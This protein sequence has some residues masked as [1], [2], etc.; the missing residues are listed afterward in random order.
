[1][2]ASVATPTL[3][4]QRLADPHATAR[5]VE[6]QLSVQPDSRDLRIAGAL[7]Y[8]Q[9]GIGSRAMTLMNHAC[10]DDATRTVIIAQIPRGERRIPW[11]GL[12]ERYQRNLAAFEARTG[13]A[14][15][16]D[17]AWKAG[18]SRLQLIETFDGELH[19]FD[20]G[21]A[22]SDWLPGFVPRASALSN[23]VL[24]QRWEGHIVR[25]I[26]VCGL[27]LGYAATAV[28][29]ASRETF[30][31]F[32]APVFIVESASLAWAVIFHLHDWVSYL[33]EPRVICV[34]GEAPLR[35]LSRELES[36]DRESAIVFDGGPAWPGTPSVE[37][38]QEVV[39]V[40]AARR[41]TQRRVAFERVDAAARTSLARRAERLIAARDKQS[42]VRIL[43]VTSRFT[44]VLQYTLRD[45]L[46][47]FEAAGHSTRLVLEADDSSYF[48][49][50]ALTAEIEQFDPDL[51]ITVDHL[52]REYARIIPPTLPMAAWIQDA[53][54]N[55]NCAEAGRS[56][57]PLQ[58]VFGVG[59]SPLTRQFGYP[60]DQFL[61]C[62]TPARPP[63]S[64]AAPQDKF[65]CDVMYMSNV[66]ETP[67][68]VHESFRK[69]LAAPAVPLA[70]AL[71]A[72]VA[73]LVEEGVIGG[74]FQCGELVHTLFP[75]LCESPSN[76]ELIQAYSDHAR[77]L[78]DRFMRQRV[79]EDIAAWAD[80]R[81]RRL[82]LYGRG[83]ESD[84]RWRRFARGPVAPGVEMS[85]AW[86]SAT[87][88]IH[89][90]LN[91]GLHQRVL[92]GLAAGAFLLIQDSVWES[93]SGISTKLLRIAE[94]RQDK[95]PVRVA[96]GDF[97][98]AMQS[99]AREFLGRICS[100][101]NNGFLMT[102]ELYDTL[103]LAIDDQRPPLPALLWS[104]Y[105]NVV[106]HGRARLWERLD[107]AVAH[108]DERA[109]ISERMRS[110]LSERLTY[111]AFVEDLIRFVADGVERA[112]S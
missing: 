35:E 7:A 78:L 74:G 5:E 75:A 17:S 44:T 76:N 85:S 100:D 77:T 15:R 20:R 31:T 19:I 54:P 71:F 9:L 41:E 38:I 101:V 30:L 29:Q 63:V 34:A 96:M 49:P 28:L 39:D 24:R 53:L 59:Y 81:G 97:P 56:V 13:L 68:Q 6:A 3:N 93:R 26:I 90:G 57:D 84:P 108:P 43:G 32:S 83:W 18:V 64:G 23:E 60:C 37:A 33:N 88:C 8:A 11:S 66:A 45:L 102:Q 105:P 107:W 36:H 42:P 103:R 112:R 2:A 109:E 4:I 98:D 106:F 27:G 67:A 69:R 86:R 111:R 70:D 82:H 79:V 104:D 73:R 65:R 10:I 72:T 55:L 94:A 61:P 12:R 40:A 21:A 95:L 91:S 1:M 92:D 89:A 87:V 110:A 58:F 62:I 48:S 16:V 14:A 99:H 46:D 51:L 52:R 80:E 50:L 47:A 25:P 22:S